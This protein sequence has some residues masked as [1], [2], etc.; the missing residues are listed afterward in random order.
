M[1][2]L[3]VQTESRN[4]WRDGNHLSAATMPSL[5]T[6]LWQDDGR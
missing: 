3:H 6:M 5:P 1:N 2:L 4:D